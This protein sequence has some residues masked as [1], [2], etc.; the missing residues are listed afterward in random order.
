[1][2]FECC[3]NM[4]GTKNR[5]N[6]DQ[7]DFIRGTLK[8]SLPDRQYSE[9]VMAADHVDGAGFSRSQSTPDTVVEEDSFNPDI[10]PDG[11]CISPQKLAARQQDTHHSA[12][13][14]AEVWFSFSLHDLHAQC[15]IF[16]CMGTFS[17]I[18]E[19]IIWFLAP[20]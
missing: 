15:C 14:D 1:M 5:K 8:P 4:K 3:S 9:P 12:V 16:D 13:R 10:L 19:E 20:L 6:S 11:I 2:R 17:C 7:A 18:L